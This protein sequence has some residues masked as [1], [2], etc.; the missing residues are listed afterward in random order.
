MTNRFSTL[1][2]R[3]T[4]CRRSLSFRLSK[5]GDT[6]QGNSQAVSKVLALLLLLLLLILL[7]IL[8]PL[9]WLLLLLLLELLLVELERNCD[10]NFTSPSRKVVSCFKN[11]ACLAMPNVDFE[12]ASCGDRDGLAA[13]SMSATA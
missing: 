3:A 1:R 13:R 4:A 10:R 2:L 7:A 5:E 12:S 6:S 9:L 11:E 8:S